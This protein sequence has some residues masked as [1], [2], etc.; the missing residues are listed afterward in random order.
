MRRM[1]I[2]TYFVLAAAPSYAQISAKE[3]TLA[4][5]RDYIKEAIG[6]SSV[7]NNGPVIILFCSAD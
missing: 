6:T 7:E 5:V 3:L 4:G 1:E 2:I